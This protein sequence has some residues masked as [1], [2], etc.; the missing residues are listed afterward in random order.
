MVKRQQ[1]W[2]SHRRPAMTS[3]DNRG[4]INRAALK[5]AIVRYTQMAA[6][7][8]GVDQILAMTDGH[9]QGSTQS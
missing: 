4:D 2:L 3:K 1:I 9:D 7:E 5:A 6:I 8:R